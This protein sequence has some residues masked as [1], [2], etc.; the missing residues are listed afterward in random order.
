MR[1]FRAVF[2][3]CL[4][5][6]AASTALAAGSADDLQRAR[7]RG[8]AATCAQCHGTDGRPAVGSIVPAL[9][10]RA[11]DRHGAANARVQGRQSTGHRDDSTGEGLQRRADPSARGL[12]RGAKMKAARGP[13]RR[14]VL[15]TAAAG[16]LGSLAGCATTRS[17]PA[18]ARVIVVGGGYGGATAAKYVR[19][20]SAQ[21]IDVTLV[22]PDPAFVSCPLSNLVL[23]GSK[24]MADITLPYDTLERTHGG[25]A[26]PRSGRAD[27]GRGA[28]RRAG[29]GRPPPVRQADPVARC[30]S[31]VGRRRRAA[32][33]QR[34]GPHPAGLESRRR[35]HRAAPPARGD[36]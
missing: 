33:G 19:L 4:W 31:D 14:R 17:G 24:A 20:L 6:G 11:G 22:E 28:H 18:A 15:Q 34:A 29:F 16:L 26:H 9:A 30:R 5:A 7:T 36:A 3:L 25:P 2:Q 23:G 13:S 12:L 27:R 8:L 10:G 21:R 32:R 1:W 35:D